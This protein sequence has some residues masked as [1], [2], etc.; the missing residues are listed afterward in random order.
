MSTGK[1]A[2]PHY[3]DLHLRPR[4][5]RH[6][7]A[8][9]FARGHFLTSRVFHSAVFF[10]LLA[11]RH[12]SLA[13]SSFIP[14]RHHRIHSSRPPRRNPASRQRH[15]QQQHPDRRNR[16]RIV[17]LH[18]VQHRLQISRHAQRHADSHRR[19]NHR[20]RQAL[21]H[22]HPQHITLLRAQRHARSNLSRP[23]RH[24]IRQQPVQPDARQHQR[25]RA[26]KSRKPR[27]QSFLKQQPVDL[28]RLRRHVLQGQIR[29]DLRH[30]LANHRN[31][32]L[33]IT[34]R[35]H[36]KRRAH[37]ALRTVHNR[38]NLP[39]QVAVLRVSHHTH[40]FVARGRRLILITGKLS[41]SLPQR[42]FLAEILLHERL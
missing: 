40:N 7:L 16:H 42:V 4:L 30:R 23:P 10:P 22:H 15:Q 32:R 17:R 11:T 35:P 36:F 25:Q 19:A 20:Q 12:S 8:P 39:P 27:H 6:S 28:L 9:S 1:L 2:C 38:I 24:F 3:S 14:Q 13:T 18:S 37:A 21:P 26:E 31:Q 33:R 34:R 41:E 5:S 29:A